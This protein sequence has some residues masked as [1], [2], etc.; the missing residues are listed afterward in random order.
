M[1]RPDRFPDSDCPSLGA[2]MS[3][4][5]PRP[6][7]SRRSF[8]KHSGTTAMVLGAVAARVASGTESEPHPKAKV[9]DCHAHLRHRSSSAWEADDRKLIEAA[10][11]LG[12]D[13]LCCSILTPR[14]P[15][16]AEGFRECNR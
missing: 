7:L 13:Q 16:T 3:P 1:T 15:A 8:L 2:A 11:R 14:R 9:I 5:R 6:P 12:I 10:D 4:H